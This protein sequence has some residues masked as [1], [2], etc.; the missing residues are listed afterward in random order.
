[1]DTLKIIILL[2]CFFGTSCAIVFFYEIYK[3]I[4]REEEIAERLKI[5]NNELEKL[6]K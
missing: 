4:K 1:M 6:F 2:L 3:I 5:S